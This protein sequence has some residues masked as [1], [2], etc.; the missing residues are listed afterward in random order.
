MDLG[1]LNGLVQIPFLNYS[2]GVFAGCLALFWAVSKLGERPV[3]ARIAE[4]TVDW[5]GR[6]EAA[7]DAGSERLLGT[8]SIAV[9]LA[10]LAL[11]F[12]FR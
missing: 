12:N 6:R 3:A 8:V 11:W 4:L 1:P 7:G 2:V 9:G 10:V 5:A